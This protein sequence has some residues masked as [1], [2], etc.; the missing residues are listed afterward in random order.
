MPE[1]FKKY[2][3]VT[4]PGIVSGNLISVAGGFFLASRGHIDIAL[5][6]STLLG[7][8]LVIASGCVFNNCVDRNMDRKMDRTQNRVLAQGLM[9]LGVAV[10]YGALLGMA[11]M[12]LLCA[13]TN[14]L[15]V[16]IVLAGFAIYVGLYSL[17]LKR[18]S[19]HATL[20]GSLAGAAPP[21]AGYCAV[22]NCFDMGAVILLLIFSLW[23]MPHAYAIAIFRYKDYAAAA[24]PVLPVKRGISVAKKH[25]IGYMLAF[26]AATL[27]LTFG[28]YTGYSYLA[29]AATM[30][31][32]WL[33]LACWGYKTSDDR[34][35][36]KKLFV[37]SILTIT[38]LSV[39][40]SLDFTVPAPSDMHLAS[41][42]RSN[43]AHRGGF[44]PWGGATFLPNIVGFQ[45]GSGEG[46]SLRLLRI[47]K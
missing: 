44:A 22:S 9:S 1:V 24:V 5:L 8:S 32:S 2:L 42:A 21:L 46:S 16:A 18:H 3:L 30:G 4:K 31:L 37:S 7:M 6:L 13:T 26:V 47:S 38:V 15:S 45:H 23:Q 29:V 43:A 20:I 39:M 25:V 28:G 19:V 17:Y 10:L 36:A 41:A 34:G 27:M 12:A 35:W 11:G 40:M 33:S 14:M